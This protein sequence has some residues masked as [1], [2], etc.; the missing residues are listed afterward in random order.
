MPE[1]EARPSPSR[2]H[3]WL[4]AEREG[5]PLDE[6]RRRHRH[7]DDDVGAFSRATGDR[8]AIRL[9]DRRRSLARIGYRLR[10]GERM[11]ALQMQRLYACFNSWS[12]SLPRFAGGSGGSGAGSIRRKK[13]EDGGTQ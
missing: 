6:R 4:T 5:D 7:L 8:G 3:P 1:S 13:S 2:H 10:S 9:G 12:R 11:T